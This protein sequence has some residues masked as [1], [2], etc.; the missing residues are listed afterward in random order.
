VLTSKNSDPFTHQ[1]HLK[2]YKLFKGFIMSKISKK[3]KVINYMS[4]GRS[5]T[6]AQ[7][8]RM[9]GVQN[10]RATISNIRETVEQF[11]NWEI[12]NEDGRYFMYDTHP[13]RRTY[14]FTRE[15]RRTRCCN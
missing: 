4:S 13:G 8:R 9:F 7:A 1:F 15:G 5:I 14:N 12:V 6:P 10:L 11:G 3:R 2:G